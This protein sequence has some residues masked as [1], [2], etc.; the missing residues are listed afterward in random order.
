M[1]D[2]FVTLTL[3]GCEQLVH[4]TVLDSITGTCIDR[5]EALH[6][7]GGRCVVLVYEKHYYRAGNRLTISPGAPAS[8]APAAEEE[9][10]CFASIGAPQSPLSRWYTTRCGATGPKP[11]LISGDMPDNR[12]HPAPNPPKRE[13]SHL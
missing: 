12:K 4:R 1:S 5:Y 11:P 7:A 9:R 13:K 2:Y 6:P 10:D 3:E 8:T